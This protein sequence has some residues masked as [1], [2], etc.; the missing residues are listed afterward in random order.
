VGEKSLLHISLI[1]ADLGIYV[2]SFLKDGDFVRYLMQDSR[3]VKRLPMIVAD[4]GDEKCV[5]EFKFDQPDFE[6][7]IHRSNNP[8]E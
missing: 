1:D 2:W 7:I 5:L 6:K 3:F 8:L 4:C